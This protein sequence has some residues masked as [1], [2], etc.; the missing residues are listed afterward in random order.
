MRSIPD[1]V[2]ATLVLNFLAAGV[3]AADLHC[4]NQGKTE[5]LH[6]AWKMRGPFARLASVAFPT[7]GYGLLRTV[8]RQ[9]N[10]L[11]AELRISAESDTEWRERLGFRRRASHSGSHRD[12]KESCVTSIRPDVSTLW[13][14]KR[15]AGRPSGSNVLRWAR[16]GPSH[17]RRPRLPGEFGWSGAGRTDLDRKSAA[18]TLRVAETFRRKVETS[19]P[20][21][22]LSRMTCSVLL[23]CGWAPRV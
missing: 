9:E 20:R 12:Q 23:G 14:D 2:L 10:L 21:W 6:Y 17:P 11:D 19:V 13:P 15:I 1:S 8:E 22:G 4:S 5:E 16:R 7:R 18:E 3:S